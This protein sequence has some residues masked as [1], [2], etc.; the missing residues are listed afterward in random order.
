MAGIDR[1]HGPLTWDFVVGARGFEPLTP[2]RKEGTSRPVTRTIRRS[3]VVRVVSRVPLS[4]VWFSRLLDQT[5]TN[6]TPAASGLRGALSAN[7]EVVE[8]QARG[9][10]L[11]SVLR[12]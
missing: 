1:A 11:G 9:T 12:G 8:T 7:Q 5:L 2:F 10:S 3:A 4:T 6:K